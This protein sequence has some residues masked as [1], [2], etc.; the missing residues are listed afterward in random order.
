[1]LP[2]HVKA[3]LV[4]ASF[5]ELNSSKLIRCTILK[6]TYMIIENYLFKKTTI[7]SW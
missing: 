3:I 2:P 7:E 4:D 6:L 1:M 5:R